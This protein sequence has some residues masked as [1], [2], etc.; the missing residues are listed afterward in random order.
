MI[1]ENSIRSLSDKAI[2]LLQQLIAIPSYSRE[3]QDTAALIREAFQQLGIDAQIHGNNVWVRNQAYD[4]SLPT[5]L[6]NSHHDTVRP[7]KLYTRN[8]FEAAIQDGKLYGLGSND[9]GG[10]LVALMACFLYFYHNT[11]LPYNLVFA[12]TAEEEISGAKG[13]EALLP[14]LGSIDCAIVGE[15]S[16][17]RMAVAEKG[18]LVLDCLVIGEAGHAAREEGENAIYKALA[19]I[20]W[21]RDYE[22]ER[23]STVLG[24]VKMSVTVIEAGTQHNVVPAT[25]RFTVDVRVNDCYSHE[26]ILDIIQQHVCCEVKARSMRLRATSIAG[27]HPLTVAGNRIGLESFG[28]STMSDKALMPFPALKLGPGDSARS[29]SAD[30]YIY[31]K[32]IE[33]GIQT[34]IQLLKHL[35]KTR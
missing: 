13:I 2:A 17:M 8:P 12:A 30:E 21:F 18:L 25:C 32:E 33:E 1:P 24:P 26:E 14:E 22:F 27:D 19:D 16:S 34:Y 4:P 29:H 11:T 23:I 3:E 15:P 7:N 31:I 5:L 35:F 10:P 28:S 9:A 20:H 6:L